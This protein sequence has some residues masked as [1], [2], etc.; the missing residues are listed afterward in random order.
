MCREQPVCPI[1]AISYPTFWAWRWSPLSCGS[2]FPQ[3]RLGRWLAANAYTVYIIHL[4]IVVGLQSALA[5]ASL[6]PLLKFVVVTI[7][8]VPLCFV[9]GHMLRK[10]ASVARAPR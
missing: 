2:G 8:A 4:L 10:I 9:L 1:T 3:E 7:A 5:N 6:P